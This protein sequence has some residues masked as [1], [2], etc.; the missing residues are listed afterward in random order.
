MHLLKD[1]VVTTHQYQGISFYLKRDDLLHPH[2]SGNKARK[3]MSVLNGSYP[4]VETLV[5]YGSVQANSL[6]SFAALSKLKG[7]E[8]EFYVDRIPHWLRENPTGNYAAAIELG[9]K[10]QVVSE[11][12]NVENLHPHDYI[13]QNLSSNQ[14][15]LCVPEGGRSPIASQ[16]IQT[17]ANEILAWK[18]QSAI[19]HLD[20]VLPS[21]TGTTSYFLQHHLAAD[22]IRVLTCSCVGGSEYLQAQW[23]TLESDYLLNQAL[24]SSQG[25]PGEVTNL[26]HSQQRYPEILPPPRKHHFGKLYKED[27]LTW[28]G[29][30][31]ETGVEFDLL[32]DPLMWQTLMAWQD[33]D[34]QTPILYIHQGGLVG[35]SSMLPRYRR[36][37]DEA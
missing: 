27:Y 8:C 21:G 13:A 37:Y 12:S 31:E 19:N 15:N 11:L 6:L 1:T 34:P 20:V 2:F 30:K 23:E 9:A 28:Q 22:G 29:L 14:R 25:A 10:I 35:N 36:R 5:G 7:W 17:L 16:G 3:L 4:D 24:T 33:R 26:I 18:A 32:Y